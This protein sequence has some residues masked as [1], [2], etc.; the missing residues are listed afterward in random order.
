MTGSEAMWIKLGS[1]LGAVL[2]CAP[3]ASAQQ[4]TSNIVDT[5][6]L[7]VCSD[8]ANMPLSS[9]AGAG[10]ENKIAELIATEL[11]IPVSYTW[12][13]MATGFVRQTLAAGRCDVIMGYVQ[14][15]ELVQNTN[16]YYRSSYVIVYKK[17][18]SLDGLVDLNDERLKGKAIGV[19]AGSPPSDTLAKNGLMGNVRPY[20]LM[21]DRRFD[22]P[23]EQMVKDLEKGDI[24]AGILWGPIG[25]YYAKKAGS[26]MTVQ[27]LVKETKGP[28][29]IYRITFGVR[30]HD[31]EWK[32][33]LNGLI[34]KNQTKINA[35]LL[36]YGVP[37]LDE[38]DALITQ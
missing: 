33:K 15:D 10:F 14:G 23:S 11:K 30:P 4:E 12:F 17:G 27:P 21:V 20:A 8:P 25:G 9:T 38:Q 22:S 29:Q 32:R 36:E 34:A 3:I 18:G 26:P 28:R 37:L 2:L 7:R 35:I 24:E 16:H 5:T 13:P 1:A 19:I 31:Q 6:T